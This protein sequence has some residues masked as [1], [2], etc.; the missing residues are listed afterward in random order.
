MNRLRLIHFSFWQVRLLARYQI[1]MV[2]FIIAAIYTLAFKLIPAIQVDPVLIYLIF[3]D[4]T[5]FGF[6][7][8][9]AM[10]L[11]EKTDQTL[12]AQVITPLRTYEFLWSKAIALLAPTITCSLIMMIAAKGIH[13]RIPLFLLAIILSSLLFTFLGI[14]GVMRVKTFNQYML[15]IPLFLAP[16]SLP[17]INFFGLTD[18]KL[19][20]IIPT[21]ESLFLFQQTLRAP[22]LLP[23]ILS[24]IYLGLWVYLSYRLA[25]RE[26]IKNMYQ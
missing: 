24:L 16:T 19:L 20:Y 25:A 6:I 14:A 7:F 8:I 15:V 18:L 3:S 11:F 17:L 12:P 5:A 26:F 13:F 1:L 2:A 10:I 22:S 4:P 23:E 9:G 21:Q